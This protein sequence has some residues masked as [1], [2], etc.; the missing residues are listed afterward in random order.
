MRLL[1]FVEQLFCF[2]IRVFRTDQKTRRFYTECIKCSK[3]TRG[4]ITG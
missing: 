2:H 1:R 4:I 3:Q